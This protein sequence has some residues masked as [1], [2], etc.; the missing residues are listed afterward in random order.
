MVYRIVYISFICFLIVVYSTTIPVVTIL[1]QHYTDPTSVQVSLDESTKTTNPQTDI[2]F[3][4]ICFRI[5]TTTAGVD[6][7]AEFTPSVVQH[8][9]FLLKPF[10]VVESLDLQSFQ[11]RAP[12]IHFS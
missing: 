5:I 9:S 12:P 7:T 11:E 10:F 6:F 4:A 1:H 2:S 8:S 3:C